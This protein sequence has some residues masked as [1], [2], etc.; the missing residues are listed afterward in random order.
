[1]L[2]LNRLLGYTTSEEDS[3][4]YHLNVS[5]INRTRLILRSLGLYCV[6]FRPLLPSLTVIY[7]L[8]LFLPLFVF[9]VLESHMKLTIP[10]Y[11]TAFF[12]LNAFLIFHAL[13]YLICKIKWL[14]DHTMPSKFECLELLWS[15]L[16][17]AYIYTFILGLGTFYFWLTI[18]FEKVLF[19]QAILFILGVF[20]LP[21][22]LLSVPY[23]FVSVGKWWKSPLNLLALLWKNCFNCLSTIFCI[24]GVLA[25]LL[26][27]LYSASLN[28]AEMIPMGMAFYIATFI[29]VYFLL[30]FIAGALILL[31]NN[32]RVRKGYPALARLEPNPN[33]YAKKIYE[34][35]KCRIIP[36]ASNT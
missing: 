23:L 20:F 7:I 33:S 21:F 25:V 27:L 30:P 24:I 36:N 34:Y 12:I 11:H 3:V 14:S 29:R 31:M 6:T 9:H 10:F 22:V 17:V 26:L 28:V 8:S 35:M 2:H 15:R 32:M 18:V 1:M 19:K 16:L 13:V 5:P 4:R